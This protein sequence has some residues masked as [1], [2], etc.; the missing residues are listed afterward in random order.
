M[1]L[2]TQNKITNNLRSP[3]PPPLTQ[4]NS[5]SSPLLLHAR[6]RE[7]NITARH[8]SGAS[9]L[10]VCLR[11]II[12]TTIPDMS[13]VVSCGGANH[14]ANNGA[15]LSQNQDPPRKN[16]ALLFSP[17]FL[18]SAIIINMHMQ[19]ASNNKGPLEDQT[20]WQCGHLHCMCIL[21][22]RRLSEI[23]AQQC[24]SHQ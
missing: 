13:F 16:H 24:F 10:S 8:H 9:A 5:P 18:F 17:Q 14:V 15:M 3:A 1:G 4:Y 11:L 12:L 6:S 19:G 21:N 23:Y 7:Q 22:C 20:Q 2:R